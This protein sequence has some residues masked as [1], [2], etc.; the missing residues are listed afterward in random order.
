MQL[1]ASGLRFKQHCKT[2]VFFYVDM[3]N[4]VHDH[5]ELNGHYFFLR[6]IVVERQRRR[7]G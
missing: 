6:G 7:V 2:G 4:G 5:A 3:I 1:P